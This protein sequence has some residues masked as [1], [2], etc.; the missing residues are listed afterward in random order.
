MPELSNTF[1]YFFGFIWI[2][3]ATNYFSRFFQKMKLPLITGFIILGVFAG[4]YVLNLIPKQAIN[5]ILFVNDIALAY[6]AFAAGAELYLKDLR[7]RLKSIAWNT[8]G[9]LAVTFILSA[10]VVYFVASNIPFMA[11]LSARNRLAVSLLMATIF[12]AR[13]PS[14]AIAIIHEMRAKGPF[15]QTVMGVTVIKD[16]LVIILFAI[17]VS[18]SRNL[19]MDTVFDLKAIG[20]LLLELAL[21][22]A[23]GLI[24]GRIMHILL[25]FSINSYLKMGLIL[26]L[27]YG[28]FAFAHW[29]QRYSIENFQMELFFEPLLICIIGSFSVTNYSR[30]RAEFQFIIHRLGPYIYL[31]FFTLTGIMISLEVLAKVW[32]VAL[33]L[34]FVRL[35]SMIIGAYLGTTLAKDDPRHRSVG[36]MPYVTQAGVGLGL[37]IEVSAEFPAWGNEFATIII[38]V[39]VLNQFVG[40]PLFKLALNRVG[41]SHERANIPGFDGIQDAIIFGLEDRSLAL[42]RQLKKH[43]WEVTIATLKKPGEFDQDKSIPIQ[44]IEKLNLH[45]LN[46]LDAKKA[47][48][49]IMMLSDEENLKLCE[50][51][52]EFVGTRNVVVRLN[53]RKNMKK[54]H[55]LGCMIVDPDTAMV[56]LLDNFVRSPVAASMLLGTEDGQ[57]TVDLEVRE[58]SLH[59]VALRNLRLPSDVI[60]LSVKRRGQSI[61]SHGY[62]RLRRKDIVT[63]VGSPDSLTKMQ[64]MFGG[65]EVKK[66]K[67]V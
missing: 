38:A 59:G 46:E 21:S 42:G 6:I 45:S 62:T 1:I 35:I 23:L 3:F 4:P 2:L 56:S 10:I 44:A 63:V 18:I 39:I 24:L 48:A 14:S 22:F 40:P 25:S 51:V 31:A 8:F 67:K 5:Q 19:V 20:L 58:R 26:S 12:V 33:G 54:F 37:A 49:M 66:K 47:D 11:E 30:F 16:V 32:L 64:W 50:L 13:S 27:G 41:E 52:Y 28:V 29:I 43:G 61:I 15:T 36:W 65:S 55:D 34:F 7:S 53:E 60:I 9:Q 17:C 57:S